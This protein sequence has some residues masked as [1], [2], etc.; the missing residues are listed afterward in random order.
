MD[1]QLDPNNRSKIAVYFN[2][3]LTW[4]DTRESRFFDAWEGMPGAIIPA[5]YVRTLIKAVYG[6]TLYYRDWLKPQSF[7]LSAGLWLPPL[8]D[9]HRI[10]PA[11]DYHFD[12]LAASNE[13]FANETY[14]CI[15]FQSV[16]A[17]PELANYPGGHFG[18]VAKLVP[19]RSAK[20]VI[21]S[22]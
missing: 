2:G 20:K 12:G 11:K 6:Q 22:R 15:R 3:N 10:N 17:F 18:S 16:T 14:H 8:Y 7:G 5:R 19:L 4:F 13:L 9:A 21:F 1:E